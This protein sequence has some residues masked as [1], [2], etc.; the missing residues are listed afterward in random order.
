MKKLKLYNMHYARFL[1]I[2]V[3][4]YDE[5]DAIAALREYDFYASMNEEEW[6]AEIVSKLSI[7]EIPQVRGVF[8]HFDTLD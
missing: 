8:E 5:Q 7:T 3:W 6:Q 2:S 4:A 1:A